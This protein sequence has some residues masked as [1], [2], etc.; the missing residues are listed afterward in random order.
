MTHNPCCIRYR[1]ALSKPEGA[2]ESKPSV[3]QRHPPNI[4]F[5]LAFLLAMAHLPGVLHR[6]TAL[7][8]EQAAGLA[9]WRAGGPSKG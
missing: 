2:G 3:R 4:F 5:F 7:I 1:R 9:G 6:L 8:M